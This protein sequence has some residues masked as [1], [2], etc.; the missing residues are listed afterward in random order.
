MRPKDFGQYVLCSESNRLIFGTGPKKLCGKTV[1]DVMA[2]PYAAQIMEYDRQMLASP[3]VQDIVQVRDL[4]GK[5]PRIYHLLRAPIFGTDGQVDYIMTSASDIT[6]ERAR[7]D[8]LR[9]AS[10]VFETTT[11][12]I[13]ISDAED[14]VVMVNAAFSK[15]TGFE[16]P[17]VVG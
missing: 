6:V 2:A 3:M 17:E 15:L 1:V 10:K 12:A 5:A 14:R 13:V 4:P 16:A 11:D 8:E 9:L 7:T